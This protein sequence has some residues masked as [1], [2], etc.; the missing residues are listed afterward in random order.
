MIWHLGENVLSLTQLI[1]NWPITIDFKDN[2]GHS[3][4]NHACLLLQKENALTIKKP[5]QLTNDDKIF[6]QEISPAW[7][8][9]FATEKKK[10]IN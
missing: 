3:A 9:S 8:S 2:S 4:W 1:N 6:L 5:H 7:I 10:L